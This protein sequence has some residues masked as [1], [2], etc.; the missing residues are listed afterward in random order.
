MRNPLEASPI[1]TG[2]KSKFKNQE[3][4]MELP[5]NKDNFLALQAAK[6]TS[7]NRLEKALVN[8]EEAK[9]ALE[10]KD[11]ELTTLKADQDQALI[12]VAV[13]AKEDFVTQTET[14]IKEAFAQGVESEDT[15]ISMMN[16]E[17]DEGASK[18]LLDAEKTEALPQTEGQVENAWAGIVKK[19]G[20]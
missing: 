15:V 10:T 6:A 1:A 2:D 18:I 19:A 12:D 14:R 5:F 3:N 13:K 16:A 17:D 11:L 20:M 7:D 4:Y 9:T 8:Y